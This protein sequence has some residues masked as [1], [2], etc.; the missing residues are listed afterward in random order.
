M[1]TLLS[2]WRAFT[3]GAYRADDLRLQRRHQPLRRAGAGA[4][5]AWTRRHVRRR[6]ELSRPRRAARLPRRASRRRR[7]RRDERAEPGSAAR[8]Q[9][10]PFGVYPYPRLYRP[11]RA[12]A[13]RGSARRL[14]RSRSAGRLAV[15]GRR[16]LHPRPHW[17]PARHPHPYPRHDSLYTGQP[18]ATATWP[19]QNAGPNSQPHHMGCRPCADERVFRPAHQPHPRRLPPA[20]AAPLD[21][22]RQRS[23]VAAHRAR[24]LARVLHAAARSAGDCERDR[25]SLLGYAN[26]LARAAGTGSLL[27]Q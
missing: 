1:M 18:C 3:H 27:R 7:H 6:G 5:C 8:H 10:F 21:V 2:R 20:A 23:L 22:H 9:S 4:A 16:L 15:P 24:R 26:G 11:D 14:R 12:P 17:H 19:A 13:H 25:L